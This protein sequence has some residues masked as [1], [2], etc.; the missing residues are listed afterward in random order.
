MFIFAGNKD[1]TSFKPETLLILPKESY[2]ENLFITSAKEI[3]MISNHEFE[4]K[5]LKQLT[6]SNRLKLS[7]DQ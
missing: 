7:A 1:A 6:Q 5:T 4:L 2:K 3:D